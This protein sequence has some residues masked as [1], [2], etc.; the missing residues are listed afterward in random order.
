MKK[1]LVTHQLPGERIHHLGQCSDVNVW[2]GPGLLSAEALREELAGCAG[3]VCLLTD[4]VD[5]E[6]I[7]H[8]GAAVY[9]QH[10]GGGGPHRC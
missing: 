2:M 8:A 9:F 1:V 7:D 3:L 10:V 5:A 6:L 4:R